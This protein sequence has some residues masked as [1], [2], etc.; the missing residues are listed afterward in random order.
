MTTV[1]FYAGRVVGACEKALEARPGNPVEHSIAKE[2]FELLLQA[3][4]LAAKFGCDA[5]ANSAKLDLSL[6]DAV[7]IAPFMT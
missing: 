7:M 6:E 1:P 5:T 3:A 4:R 2:R